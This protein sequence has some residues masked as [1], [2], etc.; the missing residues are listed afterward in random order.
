M[1][2]IE[3]CLGSSCFLKGAYPVLDTFLAL[4]R[5]HGL[6]HEVSVAGAFC[7]DECRHGVAV[8]IDGQI[9]SV[10]DAAAARALFYQ[11]IHGETENAS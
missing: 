3:V 1:R 8:E 5:Q 6:E 2:T 10:P 11:L 9:Y 7:K 4:I